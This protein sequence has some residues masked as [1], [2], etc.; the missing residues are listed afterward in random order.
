[1][2]EDA[3]T[4]AVKAA[5]DRYSDPYLGDTFGAA[6]AVRAVEPRAGG[7]VAHITLGFPVG[8]PGGAG[9]AAMAAAGGK[10]SQNKTKA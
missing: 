4:A 5:L 1:M 10:N 2:S 6:Q 9:G 3:S 7:H 8:G